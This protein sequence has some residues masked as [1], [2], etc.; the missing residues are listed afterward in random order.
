MNKLRIAAF[1]ACALVLSSAFALGVDEP[2]LKS[3]GGTIEFENYNG[4]HSVI[5]SLSSIKAIGAGL[6]K[7]VA[8][9]VNKSGTF[10]SKNGKYYVIH[11]VDSTKKDKLD[12]DIFVIGQDATVDHIKNLRYIIAAYLSSAYGYSEKDASTVATFV[13]VYNAVYRGKLDIFQTK[14]KDVVTSN[15]TA[16]KCGLSIKW[17]EWPG[18]SQVV[19]PL[20][21]INGGLSTVDTSVISDKKV[22][23]SMKEEDNKGVDERK[24]MV[25]IKE[26]EADNAT[27]KAQTAQK[28]ATEETKKATEQQK[29]ADTAKQQADT[30][31]KEADTAKKEAAADPT[32]KE[33]QATAEKKQ[34]TADKKQAA[35]DTEQTKADEQKDKAT[36]ASNEAEKQQDIADKKQSEAQ[37]ERTEIAKDQQKLLQDALAEAANKNAVIGLKVTDSSTEMSGMVKVDGATGET[38]RE[39]PVTV[40]RGRTILPVT[41]TAPANTTATTTADNTKNATNT[42]TP[43]SFMY[44]AICGENTK[45]A[46]VKL[47]LLDGNNMEIQKESNETVAADSV[48]VQNGT[49]YY[50]VIQN[51]SNYVVAKY[52][53][54]L[55]LILKSP[56]SVASGT[57]I[58]VTPNGLVVT[59]ADGKV[60]LLKLSDLTSITTI[61]TAPEK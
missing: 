57:P 9:D 28:T 24:N 43:T 22:V 35:A 32:N 60:L 14:Y 21:D 47:C 55:N 46:T 37:A 45:T 52:D 6:G 54:N 40:I 19:I 44:M 53:A 48:L 56:V 20:S 1:A 38:I 2:E 36:A 51:S 11:C 31:K 42:T 50:C 39:S 30:A 15:L 8:S 4:P 12:A 61:E 13:T 7:N 10:G 26:R 27:Q 49:D 5:D 17:S 59:G 34:E 25:D 18:N 3:V 41:A 16:A 58:T 23:Q 33:K 29:K